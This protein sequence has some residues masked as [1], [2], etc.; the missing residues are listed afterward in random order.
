ME[1]SPDFESIKQTNVYKMEFWSAR[2]LMPLL[3]YGRK[4]QNF[5]NVIEKAITACEESGNRREDHFTDASKGIVG[6]KGSVTEWKDYLLS[7]FACYLVAQNGDPRKPEIAA[8]QAYFAIA[9]RAHEIHELRRQQED[10]LEM[11]L[12]VSES[13]KQL[14]KAAQGAGVQSATFG[15]FVDAGYL[16][17]HRHTLQELKEKKGIADSEDYLDNITH[18]ELSAIDFKNTLTEGKL[19]SEG[20]LVW[21]RL[22]R[23]TTSLAIK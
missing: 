1:T 15:I 19:T 7:R 10:R 20:S 3:G 18:A 4:W 16:G 13:F 14:G 6:G 2:D 9:T 5:M 12:K 17:L 22:R 21:M 8:A 11:R 23:P